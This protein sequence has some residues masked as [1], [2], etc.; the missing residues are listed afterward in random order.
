MLNG[1]RV[2]ASLG[3]S[4]GY[5]ERAVGAEVFD[6]PDEHG[7]RRRRRAARR[8]PHRDAARP[9]P[10]R[11]RPAS[12]VLVLAAAGG[13]GTLLVQ[14]AARAGAEVTGAAST[15][16]K[17]AL[18]ASLGAARHE[19]ATSSPLTF[20]VV[21]DGVGGAVARDAFAQ[22]RPGG[23]MVSFG[24]ASRLLVRRHR[25]GSRRARRHAR[26]DGAPGPLPHR[27][28]AAAGPEAGHRP[29]L[30]AGARRRRPRGDRVARHAR[31][32]A[33]AHLAVALDAGWT[34]RRDAAAH[35]RRLPLVRRAHP[36]P[37]RTRRAGP[38]R[39]LDRAGH[40]P[41]RA[42]ADPRPR[43]AAALRRRRPRRRRVV[44]RRRRVDQ[45]HDRQRELL[46]DRRD[47]AVRPGA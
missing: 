13:V 29:A 20:D 10:R 24:L 37:R 6:V 27:T 7:A 41:R 16:E 23:R 47:A 21:F 38:R 36:R 43:D 39:G 28:R 2:I 26:Q 35:G 30:P 45:P 31:Q 34:P 33:P 3:G 46:D 25:R 44:Q 42:G 8:R 32:D 17:R 5:A 4:G 1:R 14:L 12:R 11:S 19:R 18:A 9:T 40:A 15:P 22:L